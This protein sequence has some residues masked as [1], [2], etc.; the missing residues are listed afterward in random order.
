V[1]EVRTFTTMTRAL[2]AMGDWLAGPGVTWVVMEATSDY[3][4]PLFYLLEAA[5]FQTWLANAAM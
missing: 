5:R 2:S 4:K 3:W 1:Q